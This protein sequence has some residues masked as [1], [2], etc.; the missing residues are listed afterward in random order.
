MILGILHFIGILFLVL[1]IF[2]LLIVVHE[3]GHF[4]AARWRGLVVE[5]FAIWFG[6]PLW[7]KKIGGVLYSLGSIPAGGFVKLP[8][9]APMEA[10][11][12]KS[13]SDHAQ[14]PRVSALDKIIVAAAGP[15]FSMLLALVF[16]IMVWAVGRPVPEADG[17][18]RVGHVLPGSPAEQAGLQPGD[19]ILEVDG[20]PV[21]RFRGM[22]ESV[23]WHVIRSEGETIPFL[24]ER[25]GETLELEATPIREP[26]RR[27]G[28]AGL[29]QVL[30]Q[31]AV[32]PVVARIAEGSLAE[33]AGL[34]QNDRILSVNG[35]PLYHYEGLAR[36]IAENPG[37]ELQ[38]EVDR[39]G[40]SLVVSVLPPETR[41]V[42]EQV[43]ADSPA[44]EAGLQQGDVIVELDGEPIGG[45]PAFISEVSGRAGE[46]L[47]FTVERPGSGETLQLEVTPRRMAGQQRAG[48]GVSLGG[49]DPLGITWDFYGDIALVH[50]GP[51]EQIRDSV[52]T[53]GNTI[54]AIFS[55]GSDLGAQH[56]SG[57][58]GI[59]RIY[60]LLFESEQGWRLVLWFSV[61]LNVNLALLNLLPIPVL[62]GGH[63]VIAAVEGIRRRPIN[64]RVLEVVQTACALLIIGF[65]IY[66][67]FYDVGDLPIFHSAD[68]P[69]MQFEPDD[70]NS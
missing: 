19:V 25:D 7:S 41:V 44:E 12:G 61:L 55:R 8:Q 39:G 24:V 65:I 17:T 51:I 31:G 62:D 16:A 40:E 30:V 66:V 1:L 53:M 28:R 52:R 11:E 22:T 46:P 3:L 48:I 2:N 15:L 56:L 36:Y 58:V 67:T 10:I 42:A 63:I 50:P 35:E 5:Q 68:P 64:I 37:E 4:L 38:L 18:T 45:V 6:K 27:F 57:P 34:Q 47:Q 59:L 43:F 9:L 14:L 29:R 13:E 21:R 23:F 33:N 70:P 69:A 54:G 26:T 20:Y 49:G 60:Y 32:T